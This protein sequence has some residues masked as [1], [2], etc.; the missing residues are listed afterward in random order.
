MK[1]QP[2]PLSQTKLKSS[3]LQS[4]TIGL[5]RYRREIFAL[6]QEHGADNVRVFGSTVRGGATSDSDLDLLVTF[7]PNRSLLDRIALIQD[8]EALLGI[9]VDVVTEKALHSLIRDQVL[10]EAAPL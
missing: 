8:L 2:T 1:S 3:E 9:D 4:P 6:A 10:E 7:A 5:D